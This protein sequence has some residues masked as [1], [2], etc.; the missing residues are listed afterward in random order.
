[1][2][3]ELHDALE[4]F[5]QDPELWVGIITGT[6]E[7]A[8][9]AGADIKKWFPVVEEGKGKP[10]LL[11]SAPFRGMELWKPLIA[12]IN[13]VAIGGGLE[14]ALC[15]DLR[16][17]SNKA[18]FAF[19]VAKLGILPRLG[20]TVRLP[21]IIP[22]AKAAEMMFFGKPIDA[23][24]A[25]RI[26]LVNKVVAPGEVMTVAREFAEELCKVAPL[27]VRAI[28]E[29][30]VR[31]RGLSLEEALWI[32]NSLGLPLFETEDYE[33][34]KAAFKEKREPVFKGK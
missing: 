32:E 20:G 11:P 13:G 28:K 6:G 31:S 23:E 29:A 10:W 33:E 4:D 9:C 2:F 22:W 21:Q 12:A 27:S 3:G 16:I 19:P 30:M 15:C 24:E 18:R 1:L 25:Y 14:L 17:A 34:G 5:K 7:K 8:F 26:G